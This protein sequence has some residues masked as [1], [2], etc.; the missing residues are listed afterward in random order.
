[1]L[2]LGE[3]A[4]QNSNCSVDKSMQEL[5]GELKRLDPE[6]G[7]LTSGT[8]SRAVTNLNDRIRGHG[9]SASQLH[10]SRD[11]I[12]GKNLTLRD[13]R[14]KEVRETRREKG[15]SGA[16]GPPPKPIPPGQMVYVK[17]EGTKHCSRDPLVVTRDEGRTVIAQKM[18]RA[19]SAHTGFPK[20]QS[21]KLQIDKRFL[22][23]SKILGQTRSDS[24]DWRAD[25]FSCSSGTTA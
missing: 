21:N 7:K 10:F 20:I 2:V 11:H 12:T 13:S 6:G 8:L 19:T 23:T 1:M 4:N 14:F 3:Q 18:L 15:S 16:K 5:E 9:L 17:A 24:K 25:M 22:R